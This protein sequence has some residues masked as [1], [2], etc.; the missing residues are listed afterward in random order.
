MNLTE[1]AAVWFRI[2]NPNLRSYDLGQ[3][4]KYICKINLDQLIIRIR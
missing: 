1:D 2:K 3:S 4:L